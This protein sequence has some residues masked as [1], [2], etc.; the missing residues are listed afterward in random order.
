RDL[1]PALGSARARSR[2]LRG[3]P[4]FRSCK[5]GS[6]PPEAPG[7]S[8]LRPRMNIDFPYHFDELGRTATTTH[9]EHVRD[10]IE[11][12]LFTSPGERVHRPDFGSGLLQAVFAPNSAELA[13][14]LS[15]TTRAALQ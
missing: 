7:I 13:T 15:Y 2:S 10:M 6:P 14:A 12:L 4:W 9:P 8:D 5:A 1:V 11:Q 3:R